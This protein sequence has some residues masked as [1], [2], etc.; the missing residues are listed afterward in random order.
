MVH[1]FY[2]L[3]NLDTDNQTDIQ[4]GYKCKNCKYHVRGYSLNDVGTTIDP[5][6]T[7]C[8]CWDCI[9]RNKE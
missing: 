4:Y 5:C 2:K 7:K 3:S 6:P 1:D 9:N 8:Q